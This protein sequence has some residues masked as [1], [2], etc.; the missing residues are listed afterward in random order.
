MCMHQ[1]AWSI[2]CSTCIE[3]IRTSYRNWI[4]WCKRIPFNR[5]STILA[6]Q[7]ERRLSV[8]WCSAWYV[9]Y[10]NTSS[11]SHPEYHDSHNTSPPEQWYWQIAGTTPLPASFQPMKF[12]LRISL[13]NH[14]FI[15]YKLHFLSSSIRSLYMIIYNDMKRILTFFAGSAAKFRV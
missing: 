4:S 8:M 9:P 6:H 10:N 15:N 11:A 12:Y 13:L 14:N 1:D 3:T 5:L 7:P 2:T